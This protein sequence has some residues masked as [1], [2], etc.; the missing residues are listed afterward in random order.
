MPIG[1]LIRILPVILALLTLGLSTPAWADKGSG[2]GGGS[3]GGGSSGG[4]SSGGSGGGSSGS[5]GGSGHSG[6]DGSSGSGHS[7]SS[8]SGSS[9][10]SHSG[11]DDG[12]A[13][14]RDEAGSEHG[15][16]VD[17]GNRSTETHVYSGGWRERIS[18]GRY[19]IFDPAGRSVTNRRATAKDFARFRQ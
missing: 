3:S 2:G 4:G 14:G 5:S 19:Q 10:G 13:S 8:N 7:G 15:N 9:G 11:S 18:G 16:G 12:S 6:S 1:S 17:S